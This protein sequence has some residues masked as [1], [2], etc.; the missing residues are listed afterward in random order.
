MFQVFL[1]GLF[2]YRQAKTKESL[3]RKV[4]S[5]LSDFLKDISQKI[6]SFF[7]DPFID[8]CF[9]DGSSIEYV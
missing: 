9:S 8:I 6:Q 5:F 3:T 2:Q 4:E 1:T 7:R